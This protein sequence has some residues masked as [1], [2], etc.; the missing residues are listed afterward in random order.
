MIKTI[1]AV[2]L[3]SATAQ[4]RQVQVQGYM[5]SN[6]TYVAPHLRSSPDS[7][8]YNNNQYLYGKQ[9]STYQAP[10]YD[11]QPQHMNQFGNGNSYY[12]NQFYKGYGDDE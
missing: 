6:G 9:P 7:S 8:I 5:K 12:N 10:R 3:I 2:M 4:A 11:S 1:L